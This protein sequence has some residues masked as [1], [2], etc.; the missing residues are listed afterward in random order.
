MRSR[1]LKWND[2]KREF[3]QLQV[4]LV[5][6]DRHFRIAEVRMNF[7]GTNSHNTVAFGLQQLLA[8]IV[9]EEYLKNML[10]QLM[11]NLYP[12]ECSAER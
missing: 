8:A 3:A 7:L 1:R 2:V 12:A 11:K 6:V 4:L 5:L 9:L 10:G